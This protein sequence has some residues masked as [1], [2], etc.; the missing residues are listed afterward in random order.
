MRGGSRF[1]GV[2]WCWFVL[3]NDNDANNLN[4]TNIAGSGP[5]RLFVYL[6]VLSQH[7][8]EKTLLNPTSYLRVPI[9]CRNILTS[10][11]S[12]LTSYL[13]ISTSCSSIPDS[14]LHITNSVQPSLFPV[15][16]SC[17]PMYAYHL[18]PILTS[19]L[20]ILTSC[21]PIPTSSLPIRTFCLPNHVYPF[22]RYPAK[23]H[24]GRVRLFASLA[25]RE[26]STRPVRPIGFGV[27]FFQQGD[28][29]QLKG[30][31]ALDAKFSRARFWRLKAASLRYDDGVNR[32]VQSEL[33]R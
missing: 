3:A 12:I 7:E 33:L 22:G 8:V 20:L 5:W 18:L 19:Y 11:L 1:V 28:G 30:E 24:N 26:F 27:H 21:L 10:C 25:T 14:C 16:T 15:Y 9:S 17:L 6:F 13:R 32:N 31:V 29:L 4:Q 23:R 2:E